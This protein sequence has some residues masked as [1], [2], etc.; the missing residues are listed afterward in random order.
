VGIDP[1]PRPVFTVPEQGCL[2]YRRVP[3]VPLLDLPAPR[4][5]ALAA[6]VATVLGGV[7]AALHAAPV[8]R[9]AGVV[10]PDPAPLAEWRDEAVEL[11]PTVRDAV[12]A[13]HRPAVTAFLRA[14]LPPDGHR[15]VLCHND[16]GIEHVLVDP[17]AGTVTGV[18]DW[19]DAAITDPAHDLGLLHRDLGPAALETALRRCGADPATLARLRDRAVVHARCGLLAD[20]AHGL[21]TGDARY[22]DKS[23]AGLAWLFPP[24]GAAPAGS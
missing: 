24:S 4:R 9:L 3:G 21:E 2:A 11:W 13:A 8:D 10:E 17:A 22:V 6:P 18:I 12:P 23:L 20:L 7:L 16:L 1:R 15:P 5:A 14:P 19:S